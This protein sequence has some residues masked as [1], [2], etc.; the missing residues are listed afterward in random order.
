MVDPKPEPEIWVR[1]PQP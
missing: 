1:F